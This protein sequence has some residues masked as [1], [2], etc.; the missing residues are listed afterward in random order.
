METFTERRLLLGALIAWLAIAVV[1]AFIGPP[2]GH[3]EAAFAISARGD[4]PPWLYR[5][6]AVTLVAEVG[7]ALGG[8][9]WQLRLPFALL[10][11]VVPLGAYLLGR[12]AFSPRIGAWAAVA[13]ATAHPMMLRAADVLGDLPATG[14]VLVGL[15]IVV[16]ELSRED[17]P[18]FRLVL[19]APVLGAAFYFRYGSGPVI[20][21]AAAA[22]V[23]VWWRVLLRRP[24]VVI[25][26]A[27]A[28]ALALAPHVIH[29]LD[30]TGRVMGILDVSAGM[31]R[32]AYL[33]EGLV[34]Y[35][36][37]NPLAYYGAL[38]APLMLAGLAS[39]AR[40]PARWRPTVFIGLV[41]VGQLVAIGV[42]SHGQPRYVFIATALLV[43]L[44]T[45]L[46]GRRAPTRLRRAALPVA[47][48]GWLGVAIALPLQARHLDDARAPL[49][50]AA[51]TIRADTGG[52]PCTVIARAVPQLMWYSR[53]KDL[54]LVQLELLPAWPVAPPS[55]V[56]SMPRFVVSIDAVLAERPGRAR[57]LAVGDARARVWRVE[58][59]A[60]AAP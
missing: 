53:C 4:G 16:G 52:G 36:T 11:L 49:V 20:A 45:E 34:T 35:L 40:P 7:G 21:I 26:T 60:A 47:A 27:A 55:Y 24:L 57:P 28:F 19:A 1:G 30:A 41:G 3:D 12:A 44:G 9:E 29:S 38:I 6:V 13:L 54:L 31:P 43:V 10:G 42:Q 51:S 46:V 22:T 23:V 17:G 18:T 48:L 8:D 32:R 33:G 56:V 58:P 2:L 50:A 15:A 14:C 37:S 39:L 59:V 25:A 5:S